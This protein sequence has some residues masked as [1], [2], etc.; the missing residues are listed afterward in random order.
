[1]AQININTQNKRT[2]TWENNT[3]IACFPLLTYRLDNIGIK[4]DDSA[5]SPNNRRN[6][7]GRLNANKNA[8]PISDTPKHEKN[9][10]SRKNP[11]IRDIIV[12]PETTAIFAIVLYFIPAIY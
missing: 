1:M 5:P 7:F 4:A 3:N 9:V 6:I 2:I 11:K 8:A 12:V 10:T